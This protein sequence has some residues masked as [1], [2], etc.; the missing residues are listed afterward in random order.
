LAD[1]EK[2]QLAEGFN[3]FLKAHGPQKQPTND[4]LKVANI[5]REESKAP[6]KPGRHVFDLKSNNSGTD[7]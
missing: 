5:K 2:A 3:A 6:K 7:A 4:T 1:I